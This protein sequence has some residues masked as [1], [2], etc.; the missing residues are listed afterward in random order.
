MV[1]TSLATTVSLLQN[2]IDADVGATAGRKGTGQDRVSSGSD[3]GKAAVEVHSCRG[4]R[5][6]KC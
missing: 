1:F 2:R 5:E 6:N 4:G 3:L